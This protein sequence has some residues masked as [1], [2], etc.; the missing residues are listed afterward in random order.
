ML[1]LPPLAICGL[2]LLSVAS[3]CAHAA[4]SLSGSVQGPLHTPV[5]G[6]VITIWIPPSVKHTQASSQGRYLFTGIEC[7]DYLLKAEKTGMAL[8]YGALHLASEDHHEFNLVLAKQPRMEAMVGAEFPYDLP[9][10]ESRLSKSPARVVNPARLLKHAA[11]EFPAGAKVVP[12]WETGVQI[13]GLIRPNGVLDDI[14]VL[15]AP[16]PD[17]AI[18]TLLAVRQWRYSPTSVDGQPVEVVTVTDVHFHLR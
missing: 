14:I 7:G 17:L 9:S 16:N 2:F 5:E 4:C 18:T 10:T 6:T 13:A 15:S 8:L 12:G 1:K 3:P 11:P